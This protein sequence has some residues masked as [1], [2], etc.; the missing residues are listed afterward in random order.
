MNVKELIER[1]K[2][3]DPKAEVRIM[4]PEL[5]SRAHHVVDV[6]TSQWQSNLVLIE[7]I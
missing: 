7:G 3:F 4:P 2:D 5:P 6:K 1:L